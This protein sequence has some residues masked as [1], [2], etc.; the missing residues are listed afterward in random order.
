MRRKYFEDTQL[1]DLQTDITSRAMHCFQ[2]SQ[3]IIA[4]LFYFACLWTVTLGRCPNKCLCDDESLRVVCDASS[5]DVVPITL[6]PGLKELNLVNNHIKS[7]MSSFSVYN[8]LI[9]L[10][11][12]N[13]QLVTLGRDNF[14]E[15]KEL[16]VLLL[17]QNMISQLENET[18][19]G[20]GKLETLFLN[21]NYIEDIPPDVFVPLKK[22]EKLDLSRNHL[23]KF[24]DF[25]FRGLE[26][27]KTLLLRDNK[28]VTIPS[29]AFVPLKG[30]LSLDL[31]MNSFAN[32]P[33]EAFVSLKELSELSL[34]GCGFRTIQV[35][36]FKTLSS[37]RTLRLHDNDL[38]EVPT[39]TFQDIPK[40]EVLNL[41]HN[42]FP[43]LRS[44]AFQY[45]RYLRTVEISGSL[46]LQAI[47]RGAFSEN[48]DI[49]SVI[50]TH[51]P[52]FNYIDPAAFEALVQLKHINLR[53]NAFGRFDASLLDWDE[54]K[55]LDLRDNPLVCNCSALWL[56]S[57]L[58]DR[59][60][61]TSPMTSETSLV[62]CG[63]GPS[64]LQEKFLRD[65]SA[66]DLGCYDADIR[67]QIIIG[68][69]A[70][71]AVSF[72]VIVLLGVR[73]RERVAGVLKSKWGSGSKEPQYHK[74]NGE[75]VD[76]TICHQAAHQPLKMVPVT[77]L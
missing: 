66:G 19:N 51:N 63:G 46:T 1:S 5:L 34:D 37:L 52:N 39:R 8:S 77:E 38:E 9:Y 53:G 14:K 11:V 59:N 15:Q 64:G 12:S 3:H 21:D 67:R 56:W 74:T 32:I 4:L 48:A 27:L 22:L 71:A 41:G 26:N 49:E 17:H 10:D 20:L 65:L 18:F 36:A 60:S 75:D 72:A 54:L 25:A 45:L 76:T 31:G 24:N 16:K 57:L 47:D 30:L 40:L 35:G 73:F 68:V 43:R 13:N 2:V 6:N 61:T 7:I 33:E 29:R 42:K 28:F 62:R 58:R 70:A 69:V 23:T 44:K 55:S 50:M